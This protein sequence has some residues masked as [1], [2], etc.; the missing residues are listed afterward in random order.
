MGSRSEGM[1][2]D[3]RCW[4]RICGMRGKE[5]RRETEHQ[6]D[7]SDAVLPPTT[8]TSG[9]LLNVPLAGA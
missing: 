3:E 8:P 5:G 4:M 1:K 7:R 2:E 6:R 9:Y